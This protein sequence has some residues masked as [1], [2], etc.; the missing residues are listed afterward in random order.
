[1]FLGECLCLVGYF[2]M[3]R[4]DKKKYGGVEY[5]PS[6][7]HAEE[8]G[9]K[10]SINPFLLAIPSLCDLTASSMVF[11]ALTM[12]AASIVQMMGGL[13]V[14][15]TAMMSVIF[16]KR[17]LYRHHWTALFLIVGGVALVGLSAILSEDDGE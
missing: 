16:L 7:R 13:I 5:S 14:F 10:T 12:V 17:K 2:L 3:R 15:M 4:M 1:M 6:F 8:Q 9:L 11:F